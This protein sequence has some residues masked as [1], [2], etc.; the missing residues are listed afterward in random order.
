MGKDMRFLQELFESSILRYLGVGG[1]AFVVDFGATV[2]ARDVLKL[3]LWLAVTIGLAAGFVVNFAL[4]RNFAFRTDRPYAWS[5][6]LYISLVLFNW[7]ATTIGMYVLVDQFGL[8]TAS[9]KL[10]CTVLTTMWNY[11]LYRFIVF[12]PKKQMVQLG[13]TVPLP[14]TVDYV[15]PAHDSEAVLITT[16]DELRDWAQRKQQH[17]RVIIVENG[18]KD[19]TRELAQALSQQDYG[20]FLDVIATQSDKGLGLAYQ[21]GISLSTADLVVLSADDLPFGTTDIEAWMTHPHRGLAIGSK[22]HPDSQVERGIAR[23]ISSAG[24]RFLRSM[25]LHSKVGDPQGTLLADGQWIRRVVQHCQENGYLSSTEIVAIAEAQPIPI[26]ELPV[27]LTPRQ[28]NHHTRIA[29]S[30]I[31]EMGVGLMRIKKHST[32]VV[33]RLNMNEETS[34]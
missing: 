27:I 29:L 17:I 12:P 11:P 33:Q 4:Q 19:N 20:P 3:P 22:A 2:L 18:S 23:A 15:I 13:P 30:D 32:V 16:I 28:A 1:T 14:R 6:F 26:V 25:I 8:S 31:W 34:A 7:I 9:G 5:M 10:I 21:H 24:F